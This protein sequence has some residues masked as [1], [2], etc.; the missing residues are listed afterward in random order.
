MLRKRTLFI[1]TGFVVFALV[2]GL[3]WVKMPFFSSD[4]NIVRDARNEIIGIHFNGNTLLLDR[5]AM[6]VDAVLLNGKS[7]A[8]NDHV[9]IGQIYPDEQSPE[10]V[11]VLDD[12]G[13][14]ACGYPSSTIVDMGVSPPFHGTVDELSPH[15]I[16]VAVKEGKYRLQGKS[17]HATDALGDRIP[18]TVDY[19]RIAGTL[20]LHGSSDVDYSPYIGKYAFD[21]F[22]DKK[23]RAVFLSVM[24]DDQFKQLRKDINVS[25]PIEA[26]ADGRYIHGWGMRPHSGGD[27]A[28]VFVIDVLRNQ[29]TVVVA[30]SKGVTVYASGK[31]DETEWAVVEIVNDFLKKYSARMTADRRIEKRVEKSQ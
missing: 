22:A 31:P 6:D 12:C 28:G 2:S 9:N 15:E 29:I 30:G 24:S 16:K 5:K 20:R 7:I 26:S 13:G 11:V 1:T 4:A 25:S 17:V 23:L 27:P 18:V 14:S 8:S 10:I 3:I 21:L 19:D